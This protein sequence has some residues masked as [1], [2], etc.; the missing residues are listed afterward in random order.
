MSMMTMTKKMPVDAA[1]HNILNLAPAAQAA[2]DEDD[3][4]VEMPGHP[5]GFGGLEVARGERVLIISSRTF[6][7]S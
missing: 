3:E 4:V 1:A 6:F 2:E 5:E 7:L